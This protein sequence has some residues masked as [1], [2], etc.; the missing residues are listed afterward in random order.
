MKTFNL[1]EY[2]SCELYSGLIVREKQFFNEIGLCDCLRVFSEEYSYAR[3]YKDCSNCLGY[4]R[5]PISLL[6]LQ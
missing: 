5:M 3:A 2:L 6:E 4:G 1:K